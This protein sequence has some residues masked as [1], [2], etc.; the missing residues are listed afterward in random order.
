MNP[1]FRCATDWWNTPY[2]YNRLYNISYIPF[3]CHLKFNQKYT[4]K[5]MK[6]RINQ[7]NSKFLVNV[8]PLTRPI[9]ISRASWKMQRKI[10]TWDRWRAGK[11]KKARG[12]TRRKGATPLSVL[13][14]N[15]SACP[16]ITY[17][18][19]FTLSSRPALPSAVASSLSTVIP[20]SG[21]ELYP[22]QWVTRPEIILKCRSPARSSKEE[23]RLTQFFSRGDVNTARGGKE[24]CR[25][26]R[27]EERRSFFFFSS[28]RKDRPTS[29]LCGS[30]LDFVQGISKETG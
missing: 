25:E 18:S 6:P 22:L 3:F 10:A 9:V 17:S 19:N 20:V 15:Y 4:Q 23:L 28:F 8:I 5:R 1:K 29:A 27:A 2:V 12:A 14:G 21:E 13:S 7:T 26:V 30:S 11:Y 24:R 16:Q